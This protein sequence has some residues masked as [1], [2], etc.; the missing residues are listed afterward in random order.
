MV[1]ERC[2]QLTTWSLRKEYSILQQ[3]NLANSLAQT[4]LF[5]HK[6]GKKAHQEARQKLGGEKSR[7]ALKM[8]VQN[9]VAK[10]Q[11]MTTHR[12]R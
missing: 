7:D 11:N 5:R 1:K 12:R 6:I 2:K 9:R 3:P 8:Q 10:S 4:N